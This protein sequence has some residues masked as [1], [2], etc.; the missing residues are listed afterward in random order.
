MRRLKIP[1]AP[2]EKDLALPHLGI[3]FRLQN[4]V[5]YRL[6]TLTKLTW[7]KDFTV[8]P[9]RLLISLCTLHLTCS[10]VVEN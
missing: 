6:N 5:A 8:R 1:T 3:G 9:Y 4:A 10:I 7:P 2:K